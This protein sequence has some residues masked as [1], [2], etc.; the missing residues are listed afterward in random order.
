ML[1]SSAFTLTSDPAWPWTLPTLGLPAFGLIAFL[2]I[3]L[4]VWTYRGVPNA[5]RLRVLIL[6]TLRLAALL[7]ALLA[8]LRPSVALQKDLHQPSTLLFLFD[9]SES[10]TI[11]DALDGQ[12][13]W[14]ALRRIVSQCQSRL[15]RL[16]DEQNVKV[17]FHR[18]AGDVEDDDPQRKADG[19]RTDFGTAL[20]SLLDRYQH[21]RP[22]R[23]LFIFSDG[24]NN[25]TRY[26]V[27]PL[28]AKWR[29]L[30]CPIHTFALGKVTTSDK[31]SDLAFVDIAADP[32]PVP[33]KGKLTV[34]GILNA[35]GF[36]NTR[37]TLRLFVDGKEVAQ[38][39]ERLPQEEANEV[40]LTCDAPAAPGE[41]M[42]TLKVDPLRN[43]AI[44]TN[45][46]ISTY[47]P[48]S[49]EGVTI[50]YVEGKNRAWEPRFIAE[51]LARDP[52]F[53]VYAPVR[54]SVA[55]P[56]PDEEDFFQL[57]KR[58]YDVILIG[59]V[60]P[61][62]LAAGNPALIGKI[63]ELVNK[64]TGLMMIG[65]YE[66]FTSSRPANA[67]PNDTTTWKET[68]LA[69]A[70]PVELDE[71]GQIEQPVAMLPTTEGLN[72]KFMRLADGDADNQALWKALP[73][74]A[75][76]SRMGRPK[77]GAVALAR[78]D[79]ARTGTPILVG[80]QY[81]KGRVLAFAGDTTYR[82]RT[83]GLPDKQTGVEAHA[84]FWKQTM[85]WLARQ[86]EGEG[87]VW[88]KPDLRRLPAGSKLDFSVGLRGKT[89]KELPGAHFEVAV[90]NPNQ[91]VKP[92]P[93]ARKQSAGEERGAFLWTETPGE[94]RVIV[95]GTGKDIDGSDITG[96]AES[97]F[98]V[99]HD[100]TELAQQAAD[101][102]FLRDLATEGGG[103]FH[104]AEEL[105]TVL[106]ELDVRLPL[107]KPAL[108][109]Q[110]HP[111]WRAPQLTGFLVGFF[112]LFVFL[113][114]LEWFLRRSWGL[115]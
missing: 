56:A 25:G 89:G 96:T 11:Q 58:H 95:K 111:D 60:S 79:N 40:S 49:K 59:D 44:H 55:P 1:I 12:T 74:L 66:S 61:N 99:Y 83:L 9:G 51:A 52:R 85:L 76:M 57:D 2:L 47:V 54:T 64:G 21:E 23:G 72:H 20:H 98:L 63:A 35:P 80:Q 77:R 50:L 94:Y 22:L 33:V 37:V 93:T 108:T 71:D 88:V 91:V 73:K 46:E 103:Q 110:L 113:I 8:I 86:E 82:W 69:G 92:V 105:E 75:G 19:K 101:H 10:M 78:A 67:P 34:K 13:R 36:A 97:R 70:L 42:V 6:V 27:R 17:L 62:R 4:T 39:E 14:D 28:A 32:S 84:R 5:S 107:P 43:E 102:Q 114:C 38:K 65:G 18:F 41:I 29:D 106:D 30:P 100:E 24:A 3:F 81:G 16:R 112:L 87:F 45:N 31:Q 104:R 48:V 115:V 15:D 26:P 7:L 109:A 53:R 90:E 68:P